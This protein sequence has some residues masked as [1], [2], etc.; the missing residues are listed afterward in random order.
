MS[1]SAKCRRSV[2]S[3]WSAST[4]LGFCYSLDASVFRCRHACA[5]RRRRWPL[6][7]AEAWVLENRRSPGPAISSGFTLVAAAP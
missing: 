4:G 5:Q 3:I 2:R 1:I 6:L 7:L